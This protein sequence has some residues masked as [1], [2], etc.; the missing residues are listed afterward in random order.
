MDQ[1]KSFSDRLS[2]IGSPSGRPGAA[3][4]A[5]RRLQAGGLGYALSFPG[6]LVLGLLAGG[7]SR[8]AMFHIVTESGTPSSAFVRPSVVAV[9]G[10]GRAHAEI[11]LAMVAVFI[12]GQVFRLTR[13]DLI[14]VQIAGAFLGLGFVYNLAFWA[15]GLAAR[16]FS[17]EWVAAAQQVL[18]ENGFA[19]MG[20]IV[21]LTGG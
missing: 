19:F 20:F 16:L 13:T 9:G 15:P 17:R 6:A 2:R 8:Y 5:R 12:L 3:P 10:G 21:P 18:P 1:R 4:A 7:F 14:S 11:V